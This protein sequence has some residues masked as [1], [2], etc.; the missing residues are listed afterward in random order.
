MLGE[1][2]LRAGLELLRIIMDGIEPLW[3]RARLPVC[4][5]CLGGGIKFGNAYPFAVRSSVVT[6]PVPAVPPV[7]PVGIKIEVWYGEVVHLLLGS[8][9]HAPD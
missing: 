4:E 7:P 3:R 6:I 8:V 9:S 1:W 5:V 2:L